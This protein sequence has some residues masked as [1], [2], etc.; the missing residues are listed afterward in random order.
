MTVL[1]LFS[2]VLLSPARA[3]VVPYPKSVKEIAVTIV[4]CSVKDNGWCVNT[5]WVRELDLNETA[6]QGCLAALLDANESAKL[7]D[8]K[9]KDFKCNEGE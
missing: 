4:T 9:L 1:L 3:G 5:T 2:V 7:N 8:L 6:S